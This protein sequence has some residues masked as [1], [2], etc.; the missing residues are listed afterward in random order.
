MCVSSSYLDH[1]P[2]ATRSEPQASSLSKISNSSIALPDRI[3]TAK[4]AHYD[5]KP[6]KLLKFKGK[7]IGS[8]KEINSF[9]I[10]TK[11]KMQLGMRDLQK[12][13]VLFMNDKTS[14]IT[15]SAIFLAQLLSGLKP[16]EASHT[17]VCMYVGSGLIAEASGTGSIKLTNLCE[18]RGLKYD[19]FRLSEEIG[20][21][22]AHEAESQ[23]AKQTEN[24][25]IYSLRGTGGLL[26]SSHY[27]EKARRDLEKL[28]NNQQFYKTH[29]SG[30]VA[31][32]LQKVDAARNNGEPRIMTIHT[33]HTS[34]GK[35]YDFLKSNNNDVEE[36]GFIK[37][38]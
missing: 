1:N 35:L 16:T 38:D 37:I 7:S 9:S 29:C 25:G 11:N 31:G 33:K 2:R 20:K 18:E 8:G 15:H 36:V 23:C 3:I 19:V 5:K 13:D 4:R 14:K 30:F 12:G 34:P 24:Y 10:D 17:H 32:I 28:K 27:G 21:G 6:S 22:A 26:R